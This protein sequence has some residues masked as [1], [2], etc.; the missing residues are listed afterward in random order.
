MLLASESPG[1][2]SED[3][4]VQVPLEHSKRVRSCS[5]QGSARTLVRQEVEARNLESKVS[6][7]LFYYNTSGCW[8]LG[9][10]KGWSM[11]DC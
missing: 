4:E 10:H 7:N 8:A 11:K 2:D 3:H 5:K 9:K 6:T 1:G